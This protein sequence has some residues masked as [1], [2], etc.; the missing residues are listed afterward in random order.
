MIDPPPRIRLVNRDDP[1]VGRIRDLNVK[2][3]PSGCP[4][5]DKA[6]WASLVF[7]IIF[8]HLGI[9]GKQHLSNL[10]RYDAPLLRLVESVHTKGIG[11]TG[12]ALS[13]LRQE[14]VCH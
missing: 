3:P 9:L 11:F 4:S 2:R 1:K 6:A 10:S 7:R 14:S 12:S 8:Y 5:Q 13:N